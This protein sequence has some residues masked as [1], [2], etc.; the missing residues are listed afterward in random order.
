MYVAAFLCIHNARTVCS[1]VVLVWYRNM[2]V[3]L[4]CNRNLAEPN[5]VANGE[6][7][8]LQYVSHVVTLYMVILL[9]LF[10][11]VCLTHTTY[12]CA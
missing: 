7:V 2:M 8:Q 11:S 9:L 5:F 3:T 12:M 6:S 4:K 1:K 10:S